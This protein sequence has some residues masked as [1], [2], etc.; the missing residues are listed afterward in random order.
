MTLDQS[1]LD[2]L[3]TL[4]TPTV[5]N[6]LELLVPERRGSG[7][8]VK[9]LVCAR[10]ELK[11]IVGY[12]RTAV[13]RAKEPQVRQ[14]KQKSADGYYEYVAEGG[15]TPSVIVIQDLDEAYGSWWGE[16]NSNIHKGLGCLGGITDGSIRDL[17]DLATDFQLLAH[18]VGPSHAH[19]HVVDYGLSVTVAGMAVN[20]GD[21]IH[22]DQHGAVVIP[23]DVADQV[24]A[25]AATIA[26]REA[27]VIKAAQQP[28]FDMKKL[29]EA[30]KGMSEIH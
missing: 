27:V 21:L 7:F 24:T 30:W 8:T 12:A 4:D 13:I 18:A 23:I 19:V 25:A 17:P 29:R 9:P 14:P 22:A 5:C 3:A 28:G 16:V 6:A 15:P 10:P 26:A 1:L 20:H 2:D 11:P